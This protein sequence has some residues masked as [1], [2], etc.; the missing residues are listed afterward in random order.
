MNSVIWAALGVGGTTLLGTACGFL[1][2]RIT[3]IWN[4]I[5]TAFAAGVMLAAATFG[6]FMPAMESGSVLLMATGAV[7]GILFLRTISA[8]SGRMKQG[9]Q[10]IRRLQTD[11]ELLFVLAIALHK[12]P[13]GMAGGVSLNGMNISAARTMILGISL[14]NLP[15]GVI[16]IPPLLA[17]GVK[18]RN[19]ACIA[20]LTGLLN[21]AGVFAGALWGRLVLD[22]LPFALAFVGG[23][24]LDVILSQMLPQVNAV[25]RFRGGAL[26]AMLG[27]VLMACVNMLC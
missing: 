22:L 24:M 10:T 26:V 25:N 1:L 9:K 27:F 11:P 6:L 3:N 2:N 17:A 23:A 20:L 7:C 5:V 18:R 21:A 15:E 13:E 16:M 14:Q 4:E 8:L 19:A 12:F